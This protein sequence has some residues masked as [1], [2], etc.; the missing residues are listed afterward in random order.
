MLDNITVALQMCFL[1]DWQH[2][3]AVDAAIQQLRRLRSSNCCNMPINAEDFFAKYGLTLN[4]LTSYD[5]KKIY[6]ETGARITKNS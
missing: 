6:R 5:I 3:D 1:D 2:D 4:D